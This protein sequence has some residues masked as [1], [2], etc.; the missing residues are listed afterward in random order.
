MVVPNTGPGAGAS[1]AKVVALGAGGRPVQVV[2][3]ATPATQTGHVKTV[4]VSSAAA[5]AKSPCMG[6]S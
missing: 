1:G 3:G 5:P 6:L 2:A 4:V